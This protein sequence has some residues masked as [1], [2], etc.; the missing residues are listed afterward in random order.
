MSMS[1]LRLEALPW[2]CFMPEV[3]LSER[4]P[5]GIQLYTGDQPYFEGKVSEVFE[6]KPVDVGIVC[7]GFGA[8]QCGT[9]LFQVCLD[10]KDMNS[11]IASGC[12]WCGDNETIG[13]CGFCEAE[14]D[15]QCVQSTNAHSS[16]FGTGNLAPPGLNQQTSIANSVQISSIVFI[17]S[18]IALLL[19]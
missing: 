19:L 7:S 12:S 14:F 6:T 5:P 17:S 8:Y 9:V 15:E 11:C 10:H 16:C 13:K 2:N 4:L 3:T 18:I 1:P